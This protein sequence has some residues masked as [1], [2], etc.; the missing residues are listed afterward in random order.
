MLKDGWLV[1]ED[2]FGRGHRTATPNLASCGKSFT[3]IAVGI[4]LREKAALFPEGLDQKVFSSTF[5]PEESF[6]LP[7]PSMADIRLG[8]LLTFTAGIRG[9]NPAYVDGQPVTID[10]L[11][12]DGWQ[13]LVDSIVLGQRDDLYRGQRITTKSLWCEPGGGYSYATAAIHRASIMVRFLAGVEMAI[14]LDQHL[15]EPLGWSEWG[16]GYRNS[17]QVTHTPGGGGIAM[18]GTDMLRFGYLLLNEGKWRDRQ[19]VPAEYIRHASRRSRFNPHYPYSLQFTVNTDGHFPDLPK[20]AFWKAGSGGH[21]LYMVPS[22]K[23]VVW[24]LGGRDSQYSPSNTGLP[25]TRASAQQIAAR[26]DWRPSVDA[27]AALSKTLKLVI[28]SLLD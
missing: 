12:P 22:R 9:N 28:E 4:L 3:S 2:Y 18:R 20:D 26:G 24:K 6:P 17:E 23:L 7:D 25:A 16:F 27:D 5:F 11:G 14:Y 8:Q 1:Y 21:A 10:P 19:L 15:T 13:G